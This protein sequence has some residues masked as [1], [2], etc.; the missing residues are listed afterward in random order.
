M[1]ANRPGLSSI[2]YRAG[3]RDTVFS[4]MRARL[5]TADHAAT[6]ALTTRQPDDATIALLDAWATTEDVLTFYQ[7][8][9][10]NECY[11]RTATERRSV[12]ELARLVGYRV[13]PGVAASVHLAYQLDAGSPPVVI[14]AGARSNS[15]PEPGETQQAF[16][17]SDELEAR[18]EWNDLAARVT[19]SQTPQSVLSDG[20]YLAGTATRLAPSDAL[21]LDL[22]DGLP[23][24]HA[25][26]AAVE[27]Q[28]EHDRTLV[29]LADWN[30][31]TFSD[32]AV[33]PEVQAVPASLRRRGAAGGQKGD[34][35]LDLLDDLR[36][37][38]SIPPASSRAL[39]RSVDAV[40]G[41]G[42]DIYPAL[43]TS[44]QPR[45]GA[46][47]Y[48]ALRQRRVSRPTPLAVYAL[49]SKVSLFGH[50]APRE[51]RFSGG[52]V[53][54]SVE[55][56][57][58]ADEQDDRLFLDTTDDAMLRDRTIVIERPLDG[59][60]AKMEALVADVARESGL[61]RSAYGLTGAQTMVEVREPWWHPETG[62]ER[63]SDVPPA[64]G[65]YFMESLRA[66]TVY[67]RQ[68][69]LPL[70]EAPIA[71]DVR[72]S[73]LELGA[74]YDG[75]VSGRW[76]IVEG[77]RT[78]VSGT[79]GVHAAELAMIAGVRQGTAT[80][81]LLQQDGTTVQVDRPGE[82]THTFLTLAKPLA[83]RYRR[84]SVTIHG[85]VV[86]A[87]NGESRQEVLGS[88]V[89]GRTLQTFALRQPPLTH[90]SAPTPAGEQ[91]TLVVRVDEVQWHEA[92]S[93][94][95]LG[96]GERGYL[97]ATDDTGVTRVTFGTG[98][99]GA[100]LPSGQENVRA[101]YRSGIGRAGNV[102]SGQISQLATR[103]LGV[104]GVVNPIRSS[105]GADPEGLES[106]R[107][108][109]PI[110]LM[111]FDRLVSVE[112]YADFSRLFAG[113]GA[114]SAARLSNGRQRIL[115]VTIAGA[116][117]APIEPTSDLFRNLSAALHDFGDPHLAVR[118]A[119]RELLAMVISANVKVLADYDWE[120][121]EPHVRA[122][123]LEAFSFERSRLGE[124]V[125]SS[126]VVQVIAGVPGV[127]WVDLDTLSSWSEQQIADALAA[128][129][130]PGPAA[131]PTASPSPPARPPRRLTVLGDR[132]DGGLLLPAQL[133]MLLPTVADTLILTEVTS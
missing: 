111:A 118:V 119:V 32:P 33:P 86:P 101:V 49:R 123:L 41:R 112:D 52:A 87:T 110:A 28:A 82:A 7:E 6:A 79:A 99:R 27:V 130:P 97:T 105:G 95:A 16:E 11:L 75:L 34:G 126:R 114:A 21:L 39:G 54:P 77:E 132:A 36:Q 100:R 67:C 51:V 96:A 43:L 17:T 91:S 108:N 3:T 24:R 58:A 47:L 88:G 107:E 8:R 42:Q 48:A 56:V 117:D 13:R 113:I 53:L 115:Q 78:D 69:E 26:V 120:L 72:D 15:V 61:S 18:P 62:G 14:P 38:P 81:R 31:G 63:V 66:T 122:A 29:T 94:A 22:G 70:A 93:L 74:L 50:N 116:D 25:R 127:D 89:A 104:K 37:P 71:A 85:N 2:D 30:G 10:A 131:A 128:P 124:S 4:A 103:P 64:A 68:E 19:R 35:F 59:D 125:A 109:V 90:V 133:A 57:L 98:D 76:V 106:A 5:S 83:Y 23:L 129:P 45:F 1:T 60:L 84:D 46:V 80:M 73:E 44:L 12:V 92:D 121:V 55:W 40:F 20:L 9:I 102:L 65:K